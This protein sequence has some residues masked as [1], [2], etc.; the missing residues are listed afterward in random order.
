MNKRILPFFAFIGALIF[1]VSCSE[2]DVI[3]NSPPFVNELTINSTAQQKVVTTCSQGSNYTLTASFM[4]GEDKGTIGL[5]FAN[6]S[7]PEAGTYT[8]VQTPPQQGQVR[9][10]LLTNILLPNFSYL[11]DAGQTI[12]VT[13]IDGSPVA[14]LQNIFMTQSN[15]S[16]TIAVSGLLGCYTFNTTSGTTSGT[17]GGLNIP[18]NTIKIGN[19]STLTVATA[20]STMMTNYMVMGS[21]MGSGSNMVS[22]TVLFSTA[23]AP[24]AGMYTLVNTGVPQAGQATFSVVNGTT[25]YLASGQIEVSI[26]GGGPKISF[27]N[28]TLQDIN[29][30]ATATT[31]TGSF[32]CNSSGTTTSGST[33]GTT[34]GGNNN[35]YLVYNGTSQTLTNNLCSSD[36]IS[37]SINMGFTGTA[38]NNGSVQVKFQGA[39]APAAG[40]YSLLPGAT[41]ANAIIYF[42]VNGASGASTYQSTSGNVTVT[43]VG[44]K[45]RA[46]FNNIPVKLNGGSHVTMISGTATCP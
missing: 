21:A 31:V 38:G 8:I 20:C 28:V 12:S 7:S 27:S 26:V 36:S 29:N 25:Q 32:A 13:M 37:Y 40:S 6:G 34:S 43:K 2:T 23:T 4:N 45:T 18:N 42:N 3:E 44:G 5:S 1:A 19:D 24:T 17:T 41:G 22:A 35:D 16:N 39:T 9:I 30:P 33:S 15:N 14:T 10:H 11:A 46:T